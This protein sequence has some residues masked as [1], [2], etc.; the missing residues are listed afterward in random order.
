MP[1]ERGAERR[2]GGGDLVFRLEC[3]HAEVLVLRQLVED[4]RRRRDRVAA[5]EQRKVRLLRRGHEAPGERSVPGDVRVFAGLERSR[6]D[7]VRVVEQLGGLTE[8]EAGLECRPVGDAHHLV[9]GKAFVDP[10]ER[11]VRGPG[12]HPRDHPECEEVLRPLGV[13]RLH[14]ERRD[15][16]LREARH[17]HFDNSIA[18]EAFIL[19]RV[20]LVASLGERPLVEVVDVDDHHPVLLEMVQIGSEC[21][22]IHGYEH[23]GCVARSGDRVIG[24]AHLERRDSGHRAG[25]GSNLGRELRECR[26]IVPEEGRDTGESITGEL[27]AITGIAG[28]ADDNVMQRLRAVID[29][30]RMVDKIGHAQRPPVLARVI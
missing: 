4:V 24:D 10:C 7:L 17:R 9:L 2:T 19:E 6:G 21:G 18:A 15:G 1:R 30:W 3:A 14:A 13:A 8:V 28:E 5:E 11:A 27:H 26:E 16:L 20:R 12:V 25:W 22:R 29:C 23:A